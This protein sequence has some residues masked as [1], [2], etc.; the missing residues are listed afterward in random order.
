MDLEM[1]QIVPEYYTC[2]QW[3]L[4]CHKWNLS[5]RNVTIRPRI[6]VKYGS[7]CYK[8]YQNTTN[9]TNGPRNATKTLEHHKYYQY[10]YK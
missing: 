5:A 4:I 2:H 3:A 7:E 10:K 1:S 6:N 8:W 9:I